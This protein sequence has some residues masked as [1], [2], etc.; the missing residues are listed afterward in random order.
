MGPKGA[1]GH[2]AT[3]PGAGGTPDAGRARI[4]AAAVTAF[5]DKG[6]H[7]TTTR[8]IARAAGLSPAAV[9]VHHE[10]KEGLLHLISMSGHRE[11]LATMEDAVCR[12]DSAAAQLAALVRAFVT[13]HAQQ[14]ATAR[15]VNDELDALTPEHRAEV[16]ELRAA[17]DG[18][19]RGVVERGRAGGEFR[20][21]DPH[22]V[23]RAILSLGQ[24]VAHWFRPEGRWSAAYVADYYA[25][26]ALRMVGAADAA[27]QAQSAAESDPRR[28]LLGPAAGDF[29][30]AGSP[31]WRSS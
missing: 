5:G 11:L 12:E 30:P 31:G 2:A 3:G 21:E 16:D 28:S 13:E 19:C 15:V 14:R 7:A 23:A 8:D 20:V 9:Y 26:L 25:G 1:R 18:V 4:L 27:P 6:F 22:L 10:S 17:M 29:L 24:E